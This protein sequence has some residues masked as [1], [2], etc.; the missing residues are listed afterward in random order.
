MVVKS[1]SF[2]IK[3]EISQLLYKN[4]EPRRN[5]KIDSSFYPSGVDQISSRNRGQI[6]DKFTKFT[7]S[8]I[9]SI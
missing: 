1:V 2:E 3:A 6:V 9:W 4:F 8:K 5:F 7:L